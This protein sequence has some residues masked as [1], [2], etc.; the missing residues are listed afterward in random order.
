M[1]NSYYNTIK[2]PSTFV[3]KGRGKANFTALCRAGDWESAASKWDSKQL[4]ASRVLCSAPNQRLPLFSGFFPQSPRGI[5][6]CIDS[7]ID[8]PRSVAALAQMSEPQL[9][10]QYEPDSLG[11]V[12][13]A[14]AHFVRANTNPASA[15]STRAPSNRATNIPDRYG[16]YAPSNQPIGSSPPRPPSSESDSTPLLED[17]TVRLASCFTRC[18]LN[19]AQPPNKSGPFVQFRDERLT[20][21]YSLDPTHS[22]RAIDDGGV[23]LYRE[24]G[25]VAQ[26]AQ[27]EGKR[28]FNTIIDGRPVVTDGLLAQMVGE[29]LALRRDKVRDVISPEHIITILATAHYVSFFHFHI[30]DDFLSEF[31]ELST[32]DSNPA[33]FLRVDSTRWFDIK[34]PDQRH[35]IVSHLLALIAMADYYVVA[36]AE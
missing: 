2:D 27:L 34:M 26:V 25:A 10:R 4:F 20:S 11:Y 32:S 9:V 14:L 28:T 12:W 7:L 29:A 15:A 16:N 6:P 23:Q 36:A 19:Y 33:S 30:T 3:Q 22:I 8:G 24:T 13:A 5:N 17:A 18:V 1:A 31:E 21:S 35:Q